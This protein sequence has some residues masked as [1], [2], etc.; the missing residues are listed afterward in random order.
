MDYSVP[1]EARDARGDV[2]PHRVGDETVFVKKRRRPKN[3]LGWHAQR[4]LYRLTGNFLLAPP[5]R[6]GIDNVAFESGK[7]RRLRQL[8]AP[9]P[10][11]LHVEEGYFV[12]SDA[13]TT[14]ERLLRAEPERADE[15]V[16][17]GAAAL[18]RL[19]DLGE[20]HGG[21]QIKNLTW[22]DGGI[23]F[24]DFEE[25]APENL[26]AEFRMRDLYL[27][28]SSLERHGHDPDLRRIC[29][30]YDPDG[31][32]GALADLCRALWGLRVA[33]VLDNRLLTG[34]SMRDVRSLNRLID[35]AEAAMPRGIQ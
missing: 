27:F 8:G 16:E 24:I 13:G 11:V 17:K 32:G 5:R 35:K 3:P 30:W 1:R 2:F 4:C 33:R 18:R 25:D 6:T 23:N 26:L 19:H 21:A 34:F 15:V 10:H 20:V 31:S 7:L 12:M 9:V 14:L 28:A 22:R 29:G